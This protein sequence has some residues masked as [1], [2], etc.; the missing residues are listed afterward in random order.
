MSA[1][2]S[3]EA[4]NKYV[5]AGRLAAEAY[6]HA[7]QL[8]KMNSSITLAELSEAGDKYI[9]DRSVGQI[10]GGICHPTT[11]QLDYIICNNAVK[12]GNSLKADGSQLLK[13]QVGAHIDGYGAVVGGNFLLGEHLAAKQLSKTATEVAKLVLDAIKPGRTNRDLVKIVDEYM[14]RT[15]YRGVP[16]LLAHNHTQY[17]IQGPKEID[18]FPA[19]DKQQEEGITFETG[20]VYTVEV[21]I[22][23]A[24]DPSPQPAV[25]LDK[26]LHQIP[27]CKD[28]SPLSADIREAYSCITKKVGT[29]PFHARVLDD[30]ALVNARNVLETANILVTYPAFTLKD[31]SK[32]VAQSVVSFIV[33]V[34]GVHVLSASSLA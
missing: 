25:D 7:L 14:K 31:R 2:G 30:S 9:Q 28:I 3:A 22:T 15:P 1:H 23:D 17:D 34:D 33:T 19:G 10:N 26:T 5:Q 11:A 4:Y 27:P 6:C 8:A 32:A 21:W 12:S 16:G 13:L 18:L 24:E 29:F 20:E